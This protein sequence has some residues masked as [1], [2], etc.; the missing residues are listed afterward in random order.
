MKS[1]TPR[2]MLGWVPPHSLVRARHS[3]HDEVVEPAPTPSPRPAAS[4]TTPPPTRHSASASNTTDPSPMVEPTPAPT[5][6]PIRPPTKNLES[7]CDS[8]VEDSNVNRGLK[9]DCENLVAWISYRPNWGTLNWSTDSPI[10]DWDGVGISRMPPRVTSVGLVSYGL[11][12]KIPSEL[13]SPTNLEILG[14]S[15]SQLTGK[16]PAAVGRNWR[17]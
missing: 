17:S 7:D 8:A 11:T 6:H 10:S 16:I 14:L 15:G 1:G 9:S 4:G 13:G 5:M 12:G 3:A 2:P